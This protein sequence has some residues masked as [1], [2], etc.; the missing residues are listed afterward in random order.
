MS[1]IEMAQQHT[2]HFYLGDANR[3]KIDFVQI[4]M[5]AVEAGEDITRVLDD[6]SFSRYMRSDGFVPNLRNRLGFLRDM[7]FE[8]GKYCGMLYERRREYNLG[9]SSAAKICVDNILSAV[10]HIVQEHKD[11]GY[12]PKLT[13]P[14]KGGYTLAELEKSLRQYTNI[15]DMYDLIRFLEINARELSRKF[16]E[17]KDAIEVSLAFV[18]LIGD[19]QGWVPYLTIQDDNILASL[20]ADEELPVYKK[21]KG[22]DLSKVSLLPLVDQILIDYQSDNQVTLKYVSACQDIIVSAI[23]ENDDEMLSLLPPALYDKVSILFGDR[24]ALGGPRP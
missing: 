11:S 14:Y 9:V 16:P 15:D 2:N 7:A 20:V 19:N 21:M 13:L 10:G 18:N 5:K 12:N 23:K 1:Y 22:E 6:E 24:N 4:M 17:I 8:Y 3:E